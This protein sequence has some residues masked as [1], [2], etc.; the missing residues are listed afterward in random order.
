M[1]LFCQ[2]LNLHA[3]G[4]IPLEDFFTEL[5]AYLFKTNKAILYN[6]L[7]D[8]GLE[9][10]YSDAHISTQREFKPLLGHPGASRL[11]L[12]IELID[13]DERDIIFIESKVGSKES[14]GQLKRY[15][16]ILSSSQGFR[17]KYLFYI[18]R[19]F[20]PKI[21]T[22]IVKDILTS[23]VIFR[24]FRWHQFHQFLK[25]QP[26]ST[27][28]REITLF[29]DKHQMAHNNQFSSIDIIA[30]ANFTKSLKIMEETMWGKVS[31]KFET[32]LGSVKQRTTALTE[33][34][35]HG[36]YLM[37]IQMDD[38]WW[39]GLGFILKTS[40]STD[41]PTVILLLEVDPSSQHRQKLTYAMKDICEQD[42]Q[43]GWQSY[44]LS[45]ST[46]WSGI[47]IEKSLQDFLAEP[48][49][50]V[51]VKDFFLKTLDEL[52]KIKI[53]YSDLPWKAL[54]EAKKTPQSVSISLSDDTQINPE[55][56]ILEMETAVYN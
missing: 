38:K 44:N 34:Q 43:C 17:H 23:T 15:A 16:E 14:D 35:R 42:N 21:S 20:D 41:Y 11:D 22:D 18:T 40:N 25:S 54:P 53:K 26:D 2:L 19:S 31:Q 1:S 12:V 52:A 50:I 10:K 3:N 32:V 37:T 9:T 7:R 39:C 56:D 55:T 36:R 13:G 46:A 30:L 5:V 49:H 45:D 6:W 24:Q 28:V 47:F 51:A 8:L 48:D 29:M 4:N 27:L 33:L